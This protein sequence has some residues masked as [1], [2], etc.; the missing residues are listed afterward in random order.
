MIQFFVTGQRLALSQP[1]VVADTID[2]LEA[3]FHFQTADWDGRSCWAVFQKGETTHRINLKDGK[4][5]KS[6][7]L[8]LGAGSWEVNLIGTATDGSRITTNQQT[9]TVVQT[10]PMD[11]EPLGP[12]ALS[13]AE[14]IDQKAQT[15]L[16]NSAAALEEARKTGEFAEQA[17]GAAITATQA[18]KQAGNAATAAAGSAQN[19]STSKLAA[20]QSAG[21]AQT[22]KTAAE[23]A[24]RA[25]EVAREATVQASTSAQTAETNARKSAESAKTEADKAAQAALD[26]Q[27]IIDDTQITD[28]KTQ[29]SLKLYDNLCQPF[30]VT[31]PVA[32]CYPVEGYP[33]HVVSEL[34][35]QQ[36]GTGD[37]S[38]DNVRPFKP[39]DGVTLTQCGKNLLNIEIVSNNSDSYGNLTNNHNGTLTADTTNAGQSGAV[40]FKETLYELLG[41][42]PAG[43]SIFF[44]GKS[45][46][47]DSK[48][49]GILVNGRVVKFGETAIFTKEELASKPRLVT[50]PKTIVTISELQFSIASGPYEPYH[51]KAFTATLPNLVVGGELNWRDRTLSII[52][53]IVSNELF[54][55]GN[56]IGAD[57]ARFYIFNPEIKTKNPAQSTA[58]ALKPGNGYFATNQGIYKP[59]QEGVVA[60]ILITVANLVANG[61]I[62]GQVETYKTA[63]VKY[64]NSISAEFAV[65]TEPQEV[66]VTISGSPLGLSGE[67]NLYGD[68]GNTTVQGAE[69]PV[70]VVSGILSR[71]DTLEN[72]AVT[73]I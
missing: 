44:N 41:G 3:D 51:G 27:T 55:L 64:L 54:K 29:S 12:I 57:V 18:A 73:Q 53:T 2:Y 38:P 30:E 60:D 49:W 71:L 65:D 16:E 24:Q 37:P 66:P 48:W 68:T 34:A 35:V 14:Q 31:G 56:N 72:H 67:N 7:H 50:G 33:L 6:A 10:G 61:A 39:W 21:A 1:L 59:D 52:K 20:A 40:Y 11:G 4:I 36:E 32:T 26:A 58:M 46:N 63:A 45:S 47:P 28:K 22:S 43:V 13:T 17:S 5:E 70:H 15:A 42:L 69:D 62:S 25:A 23:A 8:N 9:L 19:A